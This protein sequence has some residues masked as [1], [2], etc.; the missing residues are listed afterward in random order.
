MQCL[1]V[2]L[3]CYSVGAWARAGASTTAVPNDLELRQDGV[4]AAVITGPNVRHWFHILCFM[5]EALSAQHALCGR[6]I[7]S[8]PSSN[9]LGRMFMSGIPKT[10]FHV[11][12]TLARTPNM[13]S[14]QAQRKTWHT[15]MGGKSCLIRQAALTV[16][17]AQ[18]RMRRRLKFGMLGLL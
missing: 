4:R 10:A 15:Q 8:G 12:G 11:S 13:R 14:K 7:C 1:F 2:R 16:I 18:V 5:C 3:K 17:M 6:R 9:L